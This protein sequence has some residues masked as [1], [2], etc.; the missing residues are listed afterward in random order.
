M[1][2]SLPARPSLEQLRNQAKDLPKA[3]KQGDASCCGVLR[4]LKQFEGKPDAAI[5]ARDV[6]LVE[7]QYAL[8]MEYGFASWREMRQHVLQGV[9]DRITKQCWQTSAFHVGGKY[10]LD[11]EAQALNEM[12]V[13]LAAR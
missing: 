1:A 3:H 7:V 2:P 9:T 8:A 12:G 4:P 10:V 5:L 11:A 13:A 6:S